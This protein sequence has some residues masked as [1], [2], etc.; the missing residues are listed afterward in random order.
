MKN[1]ES[2]P[3]PVKSALRV[4][5]QFP[6]KGGE[7]VGQHLSPPHRPPTPEP[8]NLDSMSAFTRRGEL[9]LLLEK[10]HEV[11]LAEATTASSAGSRPPV[12]GAKSCGWR[13]SLRP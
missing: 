4:G 3:A 8:G 7:T 5:T 11:T 2:V 9:A 10:Q 13:G 12:A 1:T 6:G